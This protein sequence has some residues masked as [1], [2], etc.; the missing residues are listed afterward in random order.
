MSLFML[1]GKRYKARSHLS[2]TPSRFNKIKDIELRV[3]GSFL[4]N[5]VTAQIFLSID[6]CDP[7]LYESIRI[8]YSDDPAL[9]ESIQLL[10]GNDPVLYESIWILYS[11]DPV[12]YKSIRILSVLSWYMQFI[13]LLLE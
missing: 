13:S 11:D 12:L 4:F 10:H 2:T 9:Y 6:Q 8:L 7:V 3:L 5:E 1:G